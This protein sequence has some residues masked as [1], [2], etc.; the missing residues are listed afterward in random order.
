V[1]D[2]GLVTKTAEEWLTEISPE[3]SRGTFKLFLGYA[4]GVGKTYSM[5]SEAIRR[6]SRGEDVAIGVVESHGRKAVAELASRVERIPL[7]KL[8]F[9]GT[10]FEEMDVDAILARKPGVVL[11]DELAHSNIEGSRHA[12]RFEDL[13]DLLEAGIDVLS[14]MNVQHIESLG[15]TVLQIT[16]V[17]IRETVPD[18]VMQRVDEVQL[19]DLTPQALKERMSRG[20]IYPVERVERALSH[21]FRPGNLIALR[22]L[23][24]RQVTQV[25]DRSLDAFLKEDG[26]QPAEGVLE[27]IGVCINA[28]PAGQYLIAR[29]SRMARGMGGELYVFYIDLGQKLDPDEWK[30]LTANLRFAESLSAHVVQTTGN[31]LIEGIREFIREYHITQLIFGRSVRAGWRWFPYLSSIHGLLRDS[32]TVDVHIVTQ[33]PHS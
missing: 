9:R 26:A 17:Q 4:P 12:K 18:W 19:V 22:E 25:V 1:N 15:P 31:K 14:T 10:L 6:A 24:L 13:M 33:E 21:F 32:P 27:R 7:R 28:N 8:D 30:G 16:G 3:K 20:E 11:A 2:P 29:G 5:L 23:A